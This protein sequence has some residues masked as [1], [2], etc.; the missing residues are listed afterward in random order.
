MTLKDIT[1]HYGGLTAAAKALRLP[2]STVSDWRRGV[3][4]GRQCQIQLETGGKLRAI[5]GQTR[6]P[7]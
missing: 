6:S 1:D 4:F 5:D 2:V 3:P 7:H